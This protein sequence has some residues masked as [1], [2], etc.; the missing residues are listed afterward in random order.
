MPEVVAATTQQQLGIAVAVALVV[1]WAVYIVFNARGHGERAQ[2]G[3]E[4]ELAPNRKPYMTDEELEGP[5]LER[6]LGWALVLLTICSVGPLVYWVREPSRQAAADEGFHE[7]SVDRG[8]SL[9]LPSD[10]PEH[11]AHFGCA[12]CHGSSGQGGSTPYTITDYLGRTRTVQWA[13]PALDTAFLRFDREE[14]RTVLIYGRANTPMPAWGIQGGGPMNA[15]QIDDLVNYV[16]SLTITA[17]EAKAR[18]LTDARALAQQYGL[19]AD[20]G[21]VLFDA[22]CARCHT[23]GYSFGEPA[24]TASGGGFGPSLVNGTELRQFPGIDN[25][26]T[27][28]TEGSEFAK[29]YGVQGVGGNEGGGMP[30]FGGQLTEAQIRAIVEYERGL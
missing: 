16:E 30:G 13:A 25:H 11:G 9:F 15:Q 21:R 6:A 24:A 23:R 1:G 26:V 28:V 5:K 27:F 17:E 20:D 14:I 12:T 3:V 18:S 7:R 2:P 8:Q 4:I 29:P 22:N 19:S 10:S